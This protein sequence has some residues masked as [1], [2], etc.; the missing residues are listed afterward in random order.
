ME[1]AGG[2]TA[3]FNELVDLYLT[4]TKQQLAKISEAIR[5]GDTAEAARLAHSCAGASATCGMMAMVP[6][7]RQLDQCSQAGD[8]APLPEL[9]QAANDEFERVRK[10]FELRAKSPLPHPS[11][12]L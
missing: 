11:N 1:F 7:L 5:Q 2:D 4:Q 10:F 12:G 6:I 9:H 8:L 3:N